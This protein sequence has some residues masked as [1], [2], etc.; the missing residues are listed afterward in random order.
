MALVTSLA[1]CIRHVDVPVG[2]GAAWLLLWI[3]LQGYNP[4]A[5]VSQCLSEIKDG[6]SRTAAGSNKSFPQRM[7]QGC[8]VR[9]STR[10]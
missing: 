1:Y 5:M 8:A 3:V 6:A 7:L 10:G 2:F 9:G 4:D